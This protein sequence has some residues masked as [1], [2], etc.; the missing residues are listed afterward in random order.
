M[1][2]EFWKFIKLKLGS[3]SAIHF[4]E[5]WWCGKVEFNGAYILA[6]DKSGSMENNLSLLERG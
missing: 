5:D 2:K 4:W 3:R 6:M 1:Y